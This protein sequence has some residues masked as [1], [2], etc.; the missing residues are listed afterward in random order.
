MLVEKDYLDED[1]LIDEKKFCCISIVSPDTTPSCDTTCFM[2]RG[3]YASYEEAKH[4]STYLE[5]GSNNKCPI[6]VGQ[7]GYWLPINLNKN[8]HHTPEDQLKILNL[9][10]KQI[11]ENKILNDDKF[12]NRTTEM[13]ENIKEENKQIALQNQ[14]ELTN[15]EENIDN[16]AE[17]SSYKHSDDECESSEINPKESLSSKFENLQSD[18]LEILNI[19]DDNVTKSLLMNDDIII[20]QRYCCIS[21]MSPEQDNELYGLKIRGIFE[22]LDDANE[23]CKKKQQIDIYSHIYVAEVGKWLEWYPDPM[24]IIDQKYSNDSL[25]DI[26]QNKKKISEETEIFQKNMKSVETETKLKDEMIHNNNLDNSNDDI[27]DENKT[28]LENLDESDQ[29]KEKIINSIFE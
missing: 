10:M 1:D 11:V 18:D 21:F 12:N 25:N 29:N 7:L 3:G 16:T 8:I 22:H 14:Q 4:R 23:Y 26:I 13:V 24:K 17:L 9:Q 28:L 2:I 19:K 6:W 15:G 27:F 20:D 5:S